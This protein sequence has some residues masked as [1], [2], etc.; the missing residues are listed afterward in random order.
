MIAAAIISILSALGF[1]NYQRAHILAKVSSTKV[2]LRALSGALEMYQV[3]NGTYPE[4]KPNPSVDPLGVFAF[5]A[6]SGL[7]TPIAYISSAAFADPF[8]TLQIQ[9]AVQTEEE[10]QSPDDPFRPPTPEEPKE[11]TGGVMLKQSVLYFSYSH[12]SKLTGNPDLDTEG[13]AMVS[14]GPDRKDSFILYH[15]FPASLPAS[16]ASFG[17]TSVADT[18]YDPTNGIMSGGDIAAFGGAVTSPAMVG[19]GSR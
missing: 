4:P 9:V 7:T 14:V 1:V 5:S 16:A 18:V 12:V 15:P 8:G 10:E 11:P 2:K 19:G 3:D 17:I 6:L 13:Y